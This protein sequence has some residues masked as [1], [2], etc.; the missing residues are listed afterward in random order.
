MYC[1]Y[2][3]V[4]HLNLKTIYIFQSHSIPLDSIWRTVQKVVFEVPYAL[5]GFIANR[6]QGKHSLEKERKSH[7]GTFAHS[8]FLFLPAKSFM[9]CSWSIW[10][11]VHKKIWEPGLRARSLLFLQSLGLFLSI[12]NLGKTDYLGLGAYVQ[13]VGF[14][15]PWSTFSKPRLVHSLL[16]LGPFPGGFYKEIM[17]FSY[18]IYFASFLLMVV[19]RWGIATP[20]SPSTELPSIASV[21]TFP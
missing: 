2:Q 15:S 4:R 6:G 17:L 5:A 14:P 19:S 10:S 16:T 8:N 9:N 21:L 18:F 12:P 11:L 20:F 1:L 7:S 13:S 3:S